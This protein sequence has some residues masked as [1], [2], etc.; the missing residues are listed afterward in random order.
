V[1]WHGH[2]DTGATCT[3]VTCRAQDEAVAAEQEADRLEELAHRG[4]GRAAADLARRARVG[5]GARVGRGASAYESFAKLDQVD[6]G[7]GAVLEQHLARRGGG[8]LRS[9]DER[10]DG[11]AEVI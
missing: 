8:G 4:V 5:V 3:S 6:A 9:D 7:G 11:D 2:Y 1:R 10:E